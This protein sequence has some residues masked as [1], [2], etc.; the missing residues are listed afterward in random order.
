MDEV[1]PTMMEEKL[2]LILRKVTR[3]VSL[4]FMIFAQSIHVGDGKKTKLL[5]NE[6]FIA[7]FFA[8]YF[9]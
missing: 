3:E 5:Q 6:D 7:K 1:L 9:A 8:S 4:N 2:H